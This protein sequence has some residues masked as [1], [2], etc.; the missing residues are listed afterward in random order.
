MK[1]PKYAGNAGCECKQYS[2]AYKDLS[3]DGSQVKPDTDYIKDGADHYHA[4][5]VEQHLAA[6]CAFSCGYSQQEAR[7]LGGESQASHRTD[8]T[9]TVPARA[10]PAAIL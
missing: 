6:S 4:A 3:S 7:S 8:A 10:A 2:D 1:G 5:A 9:R